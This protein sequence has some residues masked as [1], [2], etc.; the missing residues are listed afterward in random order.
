MRKALLALLLV[1]AAC[2]DE[3]GVTPDASVRDS[4]GGDSGGRDLGG[5][6]GG[7][8]GAG[9]G[10]GGDAGLAD[11]GSAD[12]GFDASVDAG[13]PPLIE[14]IDD[15]TVLPPHDL[16]DCAP[17]VAFAADGTAYLLHSNSPATPGVRVQRLEGRTWIP[18]AGA[19][20]AADQPIN[21]NICPAILVRA[22]GTPYVGFVSQSAT[23]RQVRVRRFVAGE[24]EDALAIDAPISAF[25]P[26]LDIAMALD[27]SDAPVVALVEF[28][29]DEHFVTVR[30]LVGSA[31]VREGPALARASRNVSVATRPDG[32]IVVFSTSQIP[33]LVG[34]VS[35]LTAGVWT[36]LPTVDGGGGSPLLPDQI[37]A[38]A[39]SITVSYSIVAPS[40]MVRATRS[41]G[42][43]FTSLGTETPGIRSTMVTLGARVVQAYERDVAASDIRTNDG[44]GWGTP[45]MLPVSSAG[46]RLAVSAGRLYAAYT[47]GAVAR[48]VRVNLP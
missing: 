28:I 31:F 25:A 15:G 40:Y 4:G 3:S 24:W 19:L 7:D 10:G 1:I 44:T 35:T 46:T 27:P 9:D 17:T 20:N 2:S 34:N 12:A 21:I 30:R 43:G 42:A 33:G 48:V 14:A 45:I 47:D 38:D 29:T 32:T 18:L 23:T 26:A 37:F 8:G 6:D 5:L 11:A 16:T 36:T 41:T 13:P 39:A 22:D